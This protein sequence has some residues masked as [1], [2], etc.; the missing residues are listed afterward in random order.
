MF[1][2]V[3]WVEQLKEVRSQFA[4]GGKGLHDDRLRSAAKKFD[5]SFRMYEQAAETIGASAIASGDGRTTLLER[6]ANNGRAADRRYDEA[7][8]L[9]QG[10]RRS[11][12]LEPL[13][14]FPDPATRDP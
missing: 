13:A 6:A 9:L 7:S 3:S 14:R 1:Q 11:V 5:Q 4:A 8:A 10:V 12:G 2:A